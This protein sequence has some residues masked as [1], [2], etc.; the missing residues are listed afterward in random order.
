MLKLP[1][2]GELTDATLIMKGPRQA[3]FDLGTFGTGLVYGLE[4][5]NAKDILKNLEIGAKV[6]AKV[7]TLDGHD[8]Y[9]ELSLFAAGKQKLWS[10]VKELKDSGEVIKIKITGSNSGGL[11][12][13]IHDLKTFLGKLLCNG[14]DNVV[15]FITAHFKDRNVKSPDDFLDNRNLAS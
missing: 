7:L 9:V 15:R 14:T 3:F 6:N 11:T 4:F 1:R 5:L 12:A 8:G 13:T 2:E 10:A